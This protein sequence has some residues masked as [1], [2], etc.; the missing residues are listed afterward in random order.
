[1]TH[2]KDATLPARIGLN[3]TKIFKMK[4][5]NLLLVVLVLWIVLALVF[6]YLGVTH[7]TTTRAEVWEGANYSMA[8]IAAV[9][10]GLFTTVMLGTITDDSSNK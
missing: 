3:Q 6:G 8:S 10:F 9:V 5:E 1:V 2:S 4:K 7:P